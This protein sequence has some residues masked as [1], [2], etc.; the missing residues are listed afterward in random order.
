MESARDAAHVDVVNTSQ[1]DA[2]DA[3]HDATR[4]VIENDDAPQCLSGRDGGSLRT[5][6]FVDISVSSG[7]RARHHARDGMCDMINAFGPGLC[8]FDRDGDG[9]IDLYLPDRA[10]HPNRLFDN[11]GR[12]RFTEVASAG[13]ADDRGE[14]VGCV[15]WDYDNDGDLDLHV[16]NVGADTL[17]RNDR[18]R[19]IDV[20]LQSGLGVSAGFSASAVP[21][22]FDG[23]GDLDLFVGQFLDLSTCTSACRPELCRPTRSFLFENRSGHFVDVARERG[24]TGA[25]ATLVARAFDYENDGDIDLYVGN[26]DFIGLHFFDRMY[27][28]DGRGH[29]NDRAHALGLVGSARWGNG[30]TMG[31]DLTDINLDGHFE[32]S[33]SN[34]AGT[35]ALIFEC[36]HNDRACRLDPD[37]LGLR[38][39]SGPVKWAM[40]HE[41][42]DHDGDPDLFMTNGDFGV[43]GQSNLYL[44][45]MGGRFD[46]WV[47]ELCDALDDT[48]SSR[49][50]VP[51]DIDGDGDQD[52]LIANVGGTVQVL[53]NDVARGH[54][55]R[56]DPLPA[57]PGTRVTVRSGERSLTRYLTLSGSFLSGVPPTLHFGLGAATSAEVTVAWP[58]ERTARERIAPVDRVVSVRAR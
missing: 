10:P 55:L 41:D 45:N 26:D 43:Q 27:I 54:W 56:I 12:G 9:D 58:D 34:G 40:V 53:R 35:P 36:E 57:L 18:G 30:A 14:S 5:A 3:A 22:D 32:L 20:T 24:I 38:V 1:G 44:V 15:A 4:D 7:L 2:H 31:V 51:G 17:Y 16:S 39:T 6:P 50:A 21:A 48:Q 37:R 46:A 19:F 23:D 11:D 49:G 29:F 25:D 42:F 33:T 8:L 52:M 47:P 28:N 13:G